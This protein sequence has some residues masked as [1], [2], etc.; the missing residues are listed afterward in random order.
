MIA[1]LIIGF[2]WFALTNDGGDPPE[3]SF[4]ETNGT[5]DSTPDPSSG[6][7]SP[8]FPAESPPTFTPTPSGATTTTA[9]ATTTTPTTTTAISSPDTITTHPPRVC[10]VN[11]PSTETE[12]S[13]SPRIVQLTGEHSAALAIAISRNLYTCAN[14][15]IV[16]HPTDLYSA[17]IAAQLAVLHTSPMLYYLRGA[18][19]EETLAEEL[20]RLAPRRV[21]LMEGMPASL[22]PPG[23]QI[24]RM[25]S[26][27]E[28]LTEW[29]QL[30]DPTV[31]LGYFP[32]LG[33]RSLHSLVMIA[34][35]LK[36]VLAPFTWP[37]LEPSEEMVMGS[38]DRPLRSPRLWVVDPNRP[39]AGLAVAAAAFT[40][41]EAAIY[42]NPDQQ[43]GWI[44]VGKVLEA[45]AADVAEIWVAGPV[46][47]SGRWL[48][49]STVSGPE[50]PG[51]GRTMFPDR[52]LVAFYG[53]TSTSR[54]G[55]LGEQG[56]QETLE[57]LQPYLG[58][59]TADGT[60]TI[61]TFEIIAT[62]A[63]GAAG[64]DGNYS[65]EFSI[66]T[67][68][69]WV[70]FAGEN[71]VYVVLD[72]QPG[73]TDFLT[74]AKQYEELLKL[75]HVGLALDPEWRLE[76]N[77]VHLVQIGSVDAL[78]VNAVIEWLAALVREERLP[79]KLL[80]VHQFRFSMFPNREL[81]T[82]PPELAVVIHMDGQGSLGS[83]YNTWEALVA[84]TEDRGWFWGWKNFFDEDFPLATP[85]QV[86]D[87]TP[88]PFFVSYQ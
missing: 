77:E 29:I 20:E 88:V 68:M 30:H 32:T 50:L 19:S 86:L 62:L 67:L 33:H 51:G 2:L 14:D 66:E 73:R 71:G 75:P 37:L 78:E 48:L 12:G 53:A 74:Q 7:Q 39:A 70:D 3:D 82:T 13:A 8:E 41:G 21:W 45:Q 38:A 65:G 80:M 17:T 46:S 49:E 56:P 84:G 43:G 23:A 28:D 26:R 1:I 16:T 61:P 44:E 5:L 9:A 64:E 58:E 10:D 42:W 83:K 57:R 87:L 36:M 76:A 18:S 4:V 24:I 60:M 47:D 15:V 72:L 6:G 69:P 85:Q 31:E 81:L 34:G 79:Q 63:T 52:R 54:L 25:P 11:P 55:V 22:V 59:Y 40:L 27:P 35:G